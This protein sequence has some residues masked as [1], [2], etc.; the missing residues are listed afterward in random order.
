MFGEIDAIHLKD[1]LLS[2]MD[3]KRK[4]KNHEKFFNLF[5]VEKVA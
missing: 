2:A 4:T 1:F 3:S 5:F